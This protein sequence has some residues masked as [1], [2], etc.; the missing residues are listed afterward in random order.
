MGT[1]LTDERRRAGHAL[2]VKGPK[3]AEAAVAEQYRLQPDLPG[4][5]GPDGRRYCVR[6]V[7][8]HVEALAASVESGDPARFVE[9]ARWARGV[10]AAHEIPAGDFLVSLRALRTAVCAHLPAG[11]A[12][13]ACAHVDAA[14]AGWGADEA[15]GT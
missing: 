10:L 6:D 8:H 7:G 13:A 4:R 1:D 3:L 12:E 9:Y 15:G 11:Q 14:I 5:Y 2:R